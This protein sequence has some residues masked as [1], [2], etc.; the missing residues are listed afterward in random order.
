MT[1]IGNTVRAREI[2]TGHL[3]R[4][5][6]VLFSPLTF[7]QVGGS[8]SIIIEGNWSKFGTGEKEHRRSSIS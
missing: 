8:V 4:P 7:R 3:R 1:V 5:G 2:G 6:Q